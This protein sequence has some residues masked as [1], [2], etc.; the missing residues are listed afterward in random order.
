MNYNKEEKTS[1][2][3]NFFTVWKTTESNA[4]SQL[5]WAKYVVKLLYLHLNHMIS[6]N[7]M[8]KNCS[9]MRLFKLPVVQQQVWCHVL[10][11]M[12]A[13]CFVNPKRISQ[14]LMNSKVS[15]L[16]T[17]FFLY[18]S[19]SLQTLFFFY[20]APHPYILSLSF[21][22]LNIVDADSRYFDLDTIWTRRT[23]PF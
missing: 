12:D 10:W 14:V 1:S 13:D 18:G 11:S 15:S 9:N 8:L 20:M 5:A 22:L 2:T 6:I 17:L 23:H 3:N 21:P 19:A 4:L 16:Q 7:H